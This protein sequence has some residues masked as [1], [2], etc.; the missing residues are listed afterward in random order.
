MKKWYYRKISNNGV[1]GYSK[2]ELLVSPQS[3]SFFHKNTSQNV[4]FH[5]HYSNIPVIKIFYL[6]K[7]FM[8]YYFTAFSSDFFLNVVDC[9]QD[10]LVPCI[11]Y[12]IEAINTLFHTFF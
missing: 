5:L 4:L 7:N 6:L 1:V 9:L 12:V 11:I 3:W 2:V 10:K 8:P